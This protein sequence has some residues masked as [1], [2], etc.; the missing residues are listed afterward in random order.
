MLADLLLVDGDQ[1]PTWRSC[2][3]RLA[4]PQS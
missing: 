3:T 4:S 1:P 2:R